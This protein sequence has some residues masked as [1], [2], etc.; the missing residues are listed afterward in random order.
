[1]KRVTNTDSGLCVQ[2][3]IE[4]RGSNLCGVWEEEA[5]IVYSYQTPIV[6]YSCHTDKYFRSAES[7]SITTSKQQGQVTR[8]V[9]TQLV[10]QED[11]VAV[12]NNPT[13]DPQ[14]PAQKRGIGIGTLCRV[15][16]TRV[17][18][19]GSVVRVVTDDGWDRV[20]VEDVF[21][22]RT[23]SF[24]GLPAYDTSIRLSQLEPIAHEQQ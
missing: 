7:F 21:A 22:V 9:T 1:M 6:V 13:Y 3:R 23:E 15:T 8:F 14:T 2:H 16:R 20:T 5:Y 12:I 4:F 19:K 17:Y 24:A 10:T 18:R 11:L